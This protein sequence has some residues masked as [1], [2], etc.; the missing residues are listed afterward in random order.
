MPD[1]ARKLI[2]RLDASTRIGSGHLMRCMALAEQWRKKAGPVTFI[3]CCNIEELNQ[4]I[5]NNGFDL[6][7]IE[8]PYPNLSDLVTTRRATQNY[9]GAWIVLDGYHFD[10]EYQ[11]HLRQSGHA[12]MVIDDMAH[13]R[14]YC[15]D[16]IL[17]QNIYAPG[18]VYNHESDTRVLAGLRYALLRSEFLNWQGW[19]RD[20]PIT[21]SK[22]LV[23]M[24]GGDPHDQTLKVLQA[25]SQINGYDFETRVVIGG[26][27]PHYDSLVAST[28]ES[29]RPIRLIRDPADMSELMAWADIAV[30]A[31]GS[32]C[33]EIAYMGLPAIVVVLFD[34]QRRIAEG[35]DQ[36]GVCRN[37]G[38]YRD[39]P[40]GQIAAA[41]KDLIDSDT[42]RWQMSYQAR[43]LVDGGG[44]GRAVDYLM[45]N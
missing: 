24:G 15:A 26:G 30:V 1:K 25:L 38:W 43:R 20:I 17:N 21:A 22:I 33:L 41:L 37:L 3:A 31:G 34:N 35:F 4:R 6:V 7:R 13:L 16:V 42:T 9:P 5:K 28:R 27:Y 32:T 29:K 19:K 36:A 12:V 40:Q 10:T 14:H 18:L 8:K 11:Q 45:K 39:V 2:C 23:T 44:A